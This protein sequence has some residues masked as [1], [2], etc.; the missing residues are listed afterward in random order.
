MREAMQ[1]CVERCYG[2]SRFIINFADVVKIPKA[3]PTSIDLNQLIKSMT[4]FMENMCINRNIKLVFNPDEELEPILIDVSLFERVLMNIIKNSVESIEENGEIIITTDSQS[5]M[6]T[7]ADNGKGISKDVEK[8]I[9]NPFFSSKPQG[10]G[11][12]LLFT[13][14]VLAQ[15]DFQYS[16]ITHPDGWTRF[17]IRF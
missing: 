6:L 16:L 4:R 13:R 8:K 5:N 14:E 10:Q 2:M 1:V 11:I 15:H 3:N 12:G 17:V 9:F 7:V